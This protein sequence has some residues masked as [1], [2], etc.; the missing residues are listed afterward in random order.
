[1]ENNERVERTLRKAIKER[2][3]RYRHKKR[4]DPTRRARA[5]EVDET[6]LAFHPSRRRATN[7]DEMEQHGELAHTSA[8]ACDF[9]GMVTD[10]FPRGVLVRRG[11]GDLVLCE[12]AE[13][14]WAKNETPVAAGDEIDAVNVAGT[15]EYQATITAVHPRRSVLSL[16]EA[17][18]IHTGVIYDRILAAN[19]D[20]FIVVDSLHDPELNPAFI[21]RCLIIGQR[22]GDKRLI[23]TVNKADLGGAMPDAVGLYAGVIDQ[24]VQTS[25]TTGQGIAGLKALLAGRRAVMAGRSGVGKSSLLNA[26]SPELG[27]VT[28]PVPRKSG[29]GMHT[30]RRCSLFELDNGGMVIDTPGVKEIHLVNIAVAELTWYFPDLIPLRD[31]CRFTDCS[32]THEPRCAVKEAVAQGC[33]SAFRY[34]SYLTILGSL[35]KGKPY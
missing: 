30:T 33:L 23:L 12:I 10:V 22:E 19:I 7:L 31:G 9:T 25:A 17:D 20:T 28:Q 15:F 14:L 5:G 16:P 8:G 21:D 24:V 32:H 11:P 34:Q 13:Y 1:M 4:D 29:K 26:M 3:E 6:A 18:S 27:L 2:K 35:E